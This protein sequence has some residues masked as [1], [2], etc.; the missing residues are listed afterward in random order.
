MAVSCV[1]C[2]ECGTKMYIRYSRTANE[3]KI[4]YRMVVIGGRIRPLCEPCFADR[5]T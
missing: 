1:V 2:M 4:D 3:P 5:R